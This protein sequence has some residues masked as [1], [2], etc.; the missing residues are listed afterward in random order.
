MLMRLA[1]WLVRE[2]ASMLV[3]AVAAAARA[4]QPSSGDA[5]A[6]AGTPWM[7]T[8]NLVLAKKSWPLAATWPTGPLMRP[9]WPPKK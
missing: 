2:M 4:L 5:P 6:W 3:T 9:T 7:N 8:S 1:P